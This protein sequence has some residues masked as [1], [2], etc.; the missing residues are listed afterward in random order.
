MLGRAF[1]V[2]KVTALKTNPKNRAQ[3][4]QQNNSLGS[5][6]TMLRDSFSLV[7]SPFAVN[8]S[9]ATSKKERCGYSA[10]ANKGT[11]LWNDYL[12]GTPYVSQ[13]LLHER[14]ATKIS[15]TRMKTS[16]SNRAIAISTSVWQMLEYLPVH[17][18]WASHTKEQH[19]LIHLANCQSQLLRSRNWSTAS[20]EICVH[21]EP[22]FAS[23]PS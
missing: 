23:M 15:P 9:K 19:E 18:K 16:P 2:Y 22:G 17:V 8:T 11:R 21:P 14:D 4:P 5:L 12:K 3:F 13:S 10:L 6:A 1:L 7:S 20:V